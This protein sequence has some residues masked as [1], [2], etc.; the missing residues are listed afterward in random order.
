[1]TLSDAGLTK[2]AHNEGFQSHM[3]PDHK[4]NSIGYGHLLTPDEENWYKNGID[5]EE[6]MELLRHDAEAAE[7]DVQKLIRVELTQDQFDA[8]VD[9]RYNLGCGPLENIAETLNT[10]DYKGAAARMKL[11]NKVRVGGELVVNS[12]LTARRAQEAQ[13]FEG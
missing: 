12:G 10:G 6:A 8:L 3:Y 9:F 11:Y 5:E 13:A 2:I 4:G 1:M 7:M